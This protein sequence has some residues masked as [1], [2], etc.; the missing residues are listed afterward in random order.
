MRKQTNIL[1][2]GILYGLIVYL[3]FEEYIKYYVGQE[4]YL[5]LE[6][7]LFGPRKFLFD[8]NIFF[9]IYLFIFKLPFNSPMFVTRCRDNYLKYFISHGVQLCS[10]YTLFTL[11]IYMGIPFLMG[12]YI[13]ITKLVILNI[14]RLFIFTLFMYLVYFIVFVQSNK[15]ILGLLGAF[16]LNIVI[17]I[18]YSS[19][20]VTITNETGMKVLTLLCSLINII[21]IGVILLQSRYKEYLI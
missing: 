4:T 15:Q 10:G 3:I 12:Y 6:Q 5:F 1:L 18:I 19:V 14:T 2:W 21:C 9:V 8:M 7:A 16:A 20:S 17:L 13:P 11:V